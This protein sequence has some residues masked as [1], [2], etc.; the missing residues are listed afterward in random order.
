MRLPALLTVGQGA[1]GGA[2]TAQPA[3]PARMAAG[4]EAPAPPWVVR[5]LGLRLIAQAAA[6]G[7]VLRRATRQPTTPNRHRA[8]AAL[9][10]GAVVDGLHAA[11]MVVAVRR[12][13]SRRRSTTVS[14]G[15]A[16]VSAL[17]G[18]AAASQE[19]GPMSTAGRPYGPMSTAGRPYDP[20]SPARE[21]AS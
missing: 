3:S 15:V 13:P 14:G 17:V 1:L 5:A 2:L 18:L 16:A 9:I 21:G 6:V 11:S 10:A 4:G 19:A 7:L 20:M 8:R 12:W